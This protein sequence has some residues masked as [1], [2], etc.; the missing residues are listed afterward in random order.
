MSEQAALDWLFG[1]AD[2][3]RGVGWNPRASADEQW[4]LGRTRALLDLDGAPDRRLRCVLVA[5]TK[6]KG[7]TAAWLASLL[8]ADGRRV[9]L[10]TQPHLQSY[11]ERIRIGGLA[12]SPDELAAGVDRQRPLVQRLR[13]RV[14]E[15]GEPT[16]FE[17]TTVLALDHFAR[18][19]AQVAV[20]EV[21]LGGRLDATNAVEPAVSVIASISRDHV[22]I[23]GGTLGAI[24]S[25][26]AGIL[27]KGRPGFLAE[28][29]PAAQRVLARRCRAVGARCQTVPPLMPA[30]PV[31]PSA[32]CQRVVLP[33]LREAC[34]PLAGA[35]Q[36][37]N[38]AL[39]IAAAQ[40]LGV[41]SATTLRAGL[42]RL[43]WPGR[44]ELIDGTP[45]VVL[46]GAHN[47]DSTE[48][49]AATLLAYAG[50]RPIQLVL[51]VNR[52]K[53][54][55]ALLRP[56]LSLASGVAAT[57]V[58][59]SSRA[60]PAEELARLCRR[61]TPTA[62]SVPIH[63]WPTVGGALDAARGAAGPDGLVCVTGSLALV[64]VARTELG[65]PV[66]ER[67]WSIDS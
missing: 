50:E 56:L 31:A 59:G 5:G 32:T 45:P 11:R 58:P 13:S 52:D 62:R 4:K 10:Y 37:Q 65:R 16:T 60:R 17:L 63:A 34:L 38:A 42:E 57:A 41:H 67:L 26:K 8:D 51:G 35:H 53:E 18:V 30:S 33:G 28:Q 23:L 14:P 47:G 27:R 64:G 54:L 29:R 44:F 46:D 15:A 2:Q 12:I 48:A 9:G 21:G 7:S 40:A 24:A 3:E 43:R 6:G 49:L 61:S 19:G 36:R 20:L 39:A 55:G 1:F 25:E 66:A 22:A